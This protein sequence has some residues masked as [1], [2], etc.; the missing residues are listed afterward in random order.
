MLKST[1]AISQL[2]YERWVEYEQRIYQ[3]VGGINES[4]LQ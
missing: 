2:H 1:S 4:R 3:D